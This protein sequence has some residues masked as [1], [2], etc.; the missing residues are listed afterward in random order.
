MAII[1]MITRI[2]TRLRVFL[3]YKFILFSS[4]L[5]II[6]IF[7]SLLNGQRQLFVRLYFLKYVSGI[8]TMRAL[9]ERGSRL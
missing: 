6:L 8:S 4:Y 2:A 5:S 7:I 9:P 1:T 3:L